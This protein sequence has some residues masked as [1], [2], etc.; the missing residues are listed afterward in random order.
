MLSFCHEFGTYFFVLR[1]HNSAVLRDITGSVVKT[2]KRVYT[3]QNEVTAFKVTE[4]NEEA[5]TDRRQGMVLE[6]GNMAEG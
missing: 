4:Y 1:K 3:L 5:G 2:E 6:L